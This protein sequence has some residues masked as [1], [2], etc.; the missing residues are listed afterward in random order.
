ML[1]IPL[2]LLLFR[3]ELLAARWLWAALGAYVLA[4][5]AEY[6]D[7]AIYALGGF[8]SGHSLKHLLAALAAWWTIRAFL[9]VPGQTFRTC[10]SSLIED[11][12]VR[13]V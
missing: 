13:N 7:G 12:H 4:K 6:F 2:M 8:V 3:G 5:V 1:L 11:E 9:M 10:S